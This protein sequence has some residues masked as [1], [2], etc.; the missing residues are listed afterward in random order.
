MI[1]IPENSIKNLSGMSSTGSRGVL[2][3]LFFLLNS[4]YNCRANCWL[5]IQITVCWNPIRL[6]GHHLKGNYISRHKARSEPLRVKKETKCETD[7]RGTH[8][9]WTIVYWWRKQKSSFVIFDQHR[10]LWGTDHVKST[11]SN[12]NIN[13]KD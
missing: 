10:M 13:L 11:V 9:T 7:H 6:N 1:S 5:L 4:P 3:N 8:G 12:S 2:F